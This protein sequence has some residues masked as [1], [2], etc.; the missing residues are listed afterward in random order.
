M[1]NQQASEFF[2]LHVNGLGYLNRVR[3]VEVNGRGRKAE[4]FL[5]CS[6][7]ALRGNADDVTYTYFDLRVSGEEAIDVVQ[8]LMDTANNR[9]RK[10]LVHFRIGDIYPHGY[11]RD[12]RD[13]DRPTG[14]KEWATL[15]KGRLILINSAKVDGEVVF[16]RAQNGDGEE[17]F[18]RDG[19][20]ELVSDDQPQSP[21]PAAVPQ[22]QQAP[23]RYAE[24]AP[25]PARQPYQGRQAQGERRYANA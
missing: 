18:E 2:N 24:Q 13:R 5:A 17:G 21:E 14:Q 10:V 4:K 11:E 15:I 3:W 6:I 23:R 9:D 7:S 8:N 16:Q 20:G 19:Q 12:V 1:A 25:R 22:Q